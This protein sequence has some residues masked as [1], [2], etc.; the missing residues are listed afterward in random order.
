[1]TTP[2]QG[3]S[4]PPAPATATP[5]ATGSLALRRPVP[6]W[7]AVLLGV[8]CVL[9]VL[10]GWWF[11]TLG[12]TGEERL[13]GPL[14][15]P[16]PAETF[17]EY[18]ELH[19]VG[20]L[21]LNIVVTLRRVM[22]GFLAALGVGV[23]LGIIAGCFP[24]FG[25]FL[26]PVVMFG[27]NIPLAAVLPLL[28]FIIPGGEERKVA[29]IFIACVA[30]VTSDTE[31]AIREVAQR[32]VD[33]AYTLGASRWQA[34]SKVL[35]PLAMPS[36]FG[37]ARLL[38][39]LAFG[40]IMLA[41]SIKYGDD[42]GGLGYM[43]QLYQ[44]RGNRE[45]IYLIILIIPLVA[46]LVDQFLFWMQRSLFPYQYGGMGLLNQAVRGALHAWDDIKS[47]FFRSRAPQP[48]NAVAVA[49]SSSADRSPATP[50]EPGP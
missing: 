28:F 20:R 16:S 25:A 36:V 46:L 5:R 11:V 34:I 37:S 4:S 44:K 24:R 30:F 27:R 21:N 33:T 14:T 18:P 6:T 22:L 41:E 42:P 15:L 9:L 1:M 38:F 10:C 19:N 2:A 13:V 43:I 7:Q 48:A 35:V 29:F 45:Q 49:G 32:Y 17:G 3:T 40:Y 8:S 39:G 47:V 26:A 31:R 50:P 23:P 12:E